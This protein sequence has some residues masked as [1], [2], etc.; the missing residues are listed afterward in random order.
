MLKGQR[1]SSSTTMGL[2]RF[3]I[4]LDNSVG[5]FFPGQI[6]TGKVHI[7]NNS[8]EKTFKGNKLGK[9]AKLSRIVV[10]N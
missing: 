6:I 10:A 9:N 4:E 3:C 5:V 7:W 2:Q 8:G 1:G